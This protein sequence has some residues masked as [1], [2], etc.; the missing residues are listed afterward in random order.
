MM[1][2][3]AVTIMAASVALGIQNRAGLSLKMARTTKAPA[4]R[5]EAGDLT[6]VAE[7]TAVRDMAPPTGMAEKK[8]LKKFV[9]P[10]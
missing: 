8:L 7:L 1:L 10:R 9:M 2:R 3:T 4:M 5:P 6:P